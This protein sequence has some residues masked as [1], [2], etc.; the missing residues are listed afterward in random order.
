[1][2]CIATCM[3]SDRNLG[4]WCDGVVLDEAARRHSS[5]G[6]IQRPNGTVLLRRERCDQ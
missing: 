5:K 3:Q 4:G 6:V 1:M 2:V